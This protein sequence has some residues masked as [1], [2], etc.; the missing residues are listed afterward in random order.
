MNQEGGRVESGI[1]DKIRTLG[2]LG[3]VLRP[4]KL[5]QQLPRDDERHLQGS[6]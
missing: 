2:T 5:T 4:H 3:N 6:N 1:Q